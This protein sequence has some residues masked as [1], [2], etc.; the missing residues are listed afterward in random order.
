MLNTNIKNN[1]KTDPKLFIFIHCNTMDIITME[2]AM[3]KTQHPFS[4]TVRSF[5]IQYFKNND[6]GPQSTYNK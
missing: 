1:K 3:F 5:I 6:V 2:Y 4:Y